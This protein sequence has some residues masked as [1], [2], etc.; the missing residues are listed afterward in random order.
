[1]TLTGVNNLNGTGNALDNVIAG[2]S[3]NNVITGGAGNDTMTGNAG[4]D[5]FVFATGDTGSTSGHRDL[6][7]DFTPGT[8]KIDLN[9]TLAS[10][11]YT[12]SSP[13]ADG[14]LVLASDGAGNTQVQVN[15]HDPSW[16]YTYLVTTLDHVNP[17][18]L[19][20]ADFGYGS[21]SS[22]GG[23]TTGGTTTG[24]TTGGT[25]TGGTTTGGTTTPDPYPDSAST[26]TVPTNVLHVV[27]TG[28]APQTITANDLGD[29][30]TSNN[31][32]STIIGGAGSDT[33]IAGTGADHLTGGAGSDTF[34]FNSLPSQAGHIS[35]FATAGTAHDVLDLSGIFSAIH[36]TGTNPLKNNWLTFVSDK[37]GDTNVYVNAHTGAGPILVTTLDHVLPSQITTSDWI[38]HH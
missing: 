19:S 38:W 32:G 18:S 16:P 31:Y 20:L 17:T 1:L 25:T 7:T 5:T 34:V 10:Y 30:I 4:A 27:L 22:S 26:F 24:G 12:G 9:A 35:D 21:S 2:N 33:F 8:D 14:W 36:Y 6:I 29:T 11:G 15:P 37:H 3:G 13:I 28:T 23:T